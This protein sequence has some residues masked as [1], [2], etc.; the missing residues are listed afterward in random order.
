MR[1]PIEDGVV[2]IARARETLTFPARFMLIAARNPCPCG[3]F[4]DPTRPCSCPPASV[5]RYQKRLSGPILDRIDMHL[6]VPRV[7][8]EKLA[9][10][11]LGEGSDAIR[12]RVAT[13]R[14]RQWWRFAERCGVSANAEM[15]VPDVR[16]FCELDGS[17]ANLLK[18]AVERLGLSA[19]A[20][21]RCLRVART[22]ADLAGEERIMPVHLAEAV[23]YQPRGVEDR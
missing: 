14:Q 20:F 12:Q 18:G 13:A 7:S 11:E 10:A 2:T 23:Q 4:G 22:I 21:H 1:Q 9:G 17:G 3:Y 15:R 6:N 8:F 5:T 19:R 16:Q